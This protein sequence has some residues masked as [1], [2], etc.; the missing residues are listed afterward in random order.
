MRIIFVRHGHPDYTHDCLTELG[1]QHAE[2][3]AQR[4]SGEKLDAIYSSSCGRAYE[5]ALHIAAP[6]N[7]TVEQCDFMREIHWESVDDKPIPQNGHP[8]NTADEM[9]SNGQS[10]M[11]PDWAE[12][13]PFCR[14][15]IVACVRQV[16]EDFDRLLS[17]LGYERDGLYYRVRTPNSGTVLMASHGGS[18]SAVMSHL[19]NLPFS[20]V[21]TA[22]CPD[23][24]AISILT[25]DGEEG[26][27][28]SPRIEI[29]NDSRHIRS[30]PGQKTYR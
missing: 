12:H 22:M 30:I 4:L 3:A 17:S 8:W 26:D 1:H 27:R 10:V 18:S 11:D 19:L 14:N 16:G 2:A 20:F 23:F 29:F 5:T 6:H 25:F 15:K 28:I 21:C 13:E 24:T 9:V 7:M